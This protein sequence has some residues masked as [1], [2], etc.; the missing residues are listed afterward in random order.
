MGWDQRSE[1]ERNPPIEMHTLPFGPR[2]GTRREF[3]SCMV[4]MEKR[5]AS[6]TYRSGIL[7]ETT[8]PALVLLSFLQAL[9]AWYIA[10]IPVGFKAVDYSDPSRL[11]PLIVLTAAYTVGFISAFG[12][13]KGRWWGVGLAGL[14]AL[15]AGVGG[16]MRGDATISGVIAWACLPAG[17]FVCG[18]GIIT[19]DWLQS[20]VNEGQNDD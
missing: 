20:V 16:L 6:L 7:A 18:A 15:G 8:K 1:A 12:V 5:K 10:P 14:A 17:V 13:W 9:V 11:W 4:G 2:C 3:Q 19:H